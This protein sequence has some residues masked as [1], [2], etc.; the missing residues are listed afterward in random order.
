MDRRRSIILAVSLVAVAVVAGLLVA[1]RS[2]RH[3]PTAAAAPSTTTTGSATTTDEDTDQS[4]DNVPPVITS[5]ELAA[6]HGVMRAYL[7]A[8][9]TYTYSTDP[10][11]WT[12]TTKALTDGS[13][14]ITQQTTLP[15]GRAWAQCEQSR[16]SSTATATLQRDTVISN[17]P[18]DGA[19][20]SVTTLASTDVTLHQNTTSTQ[21]NSFSVTAT[22]THGAWKVSGLQLAGVGDAGSPEDS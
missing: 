11:V 12:L 6:A 16:C 19:G 9:G 2:Q 17:A 14:S 5:E 21:S 1:S 18:V 20:R 4:A 3:S 22:Y 13:K 15:T 8:L 7:T 10:A